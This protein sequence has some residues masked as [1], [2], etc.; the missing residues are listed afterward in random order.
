MKRATVNR[1]HN[2]TRLPRWQRVT[3]WP[4]QIA[5][6][7]SFFIAGSAKLVGTED[8]VRLFEGIDWGQLTLFNDLSWSQWFR[9]LTGSLQIL[10]AMLLLFPDRAFWG[11]LL[12][13]PLM[14]GAIVIHLLLGGSLVPA[15]VLL[16]IITAVTWF[17]RSPS[18]REL[19]MGIFDP[20][21]SSKR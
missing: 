7:A 3:V 6:A 2:K 18:L 1:F 21:S 8:M 5:A 9:H 15:L 14:V 13:V 11:G 12:Q 16:G 19:N 4:L 20:V 10:S 17:R